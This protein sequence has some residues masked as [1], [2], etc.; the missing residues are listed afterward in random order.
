MTIELRAIALKR[1]SRWLYEDINLQIKAGEVV[2]LRGPNGCGKSSLLRAVAGFLPLE[3]G[4]VLLNGAP[5]DLQDTE[6]PLQASWYGSND[7]LNGEFTARQNLQIMASLVGAGPVGSGKDL[8]PV[9]EKD[10]FGLTSFLDIEARLL[11]TGQR[12]R[13][14]LSNLHFNLGPR[15]LWLL[16]EPNSGL[17]ADGR[18]AFEALLAAHQAKGG[19]VLMA[20]HIALAESLPHTTFEIGGTEIGGTENIGTENIGMER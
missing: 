9:L 2:V 5:L 17:D 18:T 4:H 15:A 11:S 10:V 20:S 14:A 16:D 8:S 7:G 1:G 6:C 19:Y 3:E 13:L 12:Q